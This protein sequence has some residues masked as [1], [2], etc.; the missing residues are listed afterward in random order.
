MPFQK[1]LF[2]INVLF[3]LS[4]IIAYYSPQEVKIIYQLVLLYLFYKTKKDFLFIALIFIIVSRPGGIFAGDYTYTIIK[5]T[6]IGNLFFEMVFVIIA[7][8]KALKVKTVKNDFFLK[9][10]ILILILYFVLL[11][12]VFGVYKMPAIFRLTLPWLFL[13]I[14]PRLF[15]RIEDY[16]RFFNIIF[17]F[18]FVVVV[19]Q[20][21]NIVTGRTF[22]G[23]LGDTG[24]LT[25]VSKLSGTEELLRPTEGLTISFLA[26]LGA[27]FFQNYQKHIFSQK[28]LNIIIVFA[29]FSIVLSA[30]RGWI[31]AA[32]FILLIYLLFSSRKKVATIFGFALSVTLVIVALSFTPIIQTQTDKA[33]KRFETI[34]LLA[35][36]DVTAG[37]TLRRIDERAPRVMKK[38]NESPIVGSGFGQDAIDY[39][40]GHVGNQNLLLHTGVVGF[41]LF[42]LLLV[43]FIFKLFKLNEILSNKNNFKSVHLPIILFLLGLIIIHSTS[44]QV[45]GYLTNIDIGFLLCFLFAFA[46]FVYWESLKEEKRLKTRSFVS[47]QDDNKDF[48]GLPMK[49]KRIK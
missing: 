48:V 21:V 42:T 28:F 20:I 8:L 47:A 37:G 31:L 18:T 2:Y 16:A 13:F 44:V 30:T 10:I 12:A 46:N 22:A 33:I 23:L 40:D 11:I 32:L 35:Q 41:G 24:Y 14:I 43:S 6:P 27:M 4:V 39:S 15:T 9:E 5:N 7:A 1:N 45:F 29:F 26:L 34:L 17:Y 36:G 19:F 3:I 25:I 38:F 49:V